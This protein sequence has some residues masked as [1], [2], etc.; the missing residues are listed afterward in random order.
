MFFDI[1]VISVPTPP[2]SLDLQEY[3][4]DDTLPVVSGVEYFI[5]VW[6][7]VIL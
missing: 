2:A 6:W 7:L 4:T 5:F 1:Q 3:D